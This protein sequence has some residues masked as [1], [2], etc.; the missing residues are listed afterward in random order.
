LDLLRLAAALAVFGAHGTYERFTTVLHGYIGGFAHDGVVVFF[1]LSGYVI[2]YS[3]M[4]RDK[5]LATY[6]VNRAAR[7]YSV[8]I[9][10]IMMT[11]A[12][13]Y[14]TGQVGYQH[15]RLWLYIPFFIMFASDFWFFTENVFSNPPFWSLSYEVWYYVCFGALYFFRGSKRII[16]LVVVLLLVGIK[17]WILWPLWLA[18][19]WLYRYQERMRLTVSQA[20]VIFVATIVAFA[21]L[22]IMSGDTTINNLVNEALNGFP[23]E[24]LR[25]SQYF[26]GD[27]LIGAIVVANILAAR[28]A[29]FGGLEHVRKPITAAASYTFS[30]YL[31][32]YPLLNF[33][34]TIYE[35][36]NRS[37]LG[38]I[39]LLG[40]VFATIV[41]IGFFTENQKHHLRRGLSL[42]VAR[43]RAVMTGSTA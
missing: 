29:D 7:I 25:Y 27:F 12:L 9:P 15:E 14:A 35:H 21:G 4:Q 23:R 8:A 28:Y 26:A 1:V 40:S 42:V 5:D 13:D 32:H 43:A 2:T 6:A 31:L 30:I 18:G 33:F 37:L 24:T 22:K 36:D 20:R 34:A 39:G 17:L 10:A 41:V 16:L 11:L 38:Y 3:A 19:S